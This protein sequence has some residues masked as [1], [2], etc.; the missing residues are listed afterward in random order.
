MK[1]NYAL[2]LYKL[3]T[4]PDEEFKDISYVEEFGWIN[5]EQ[6]CVWVNYVWLYEFIKRMREI[7]GNGMFDEGGVEANMQEYVICIDL[8]KVLE[9]CIDIE[10]V[11][12]KNKYRH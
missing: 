4:T 3:I 9:G 2:E 10:D 11:F 12:P 5:D 8:C 6:F 7:F 1:N